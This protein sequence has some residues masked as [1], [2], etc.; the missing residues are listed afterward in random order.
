MVAAVATLEPEVAAKRALA[1]IFVCSSR[2]GMR[3]IHMAS[4]WY[5]RSVIPERIS[6]SPS[7]MKSGMEIST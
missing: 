4:V 2:P 1:A 3:V 5:M 7:R 6:S